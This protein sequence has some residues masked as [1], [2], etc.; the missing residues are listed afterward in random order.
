[1]AEESSFLDFVLNE[2][3][4]ASFL[5][6]LGRLPQPLEQFAFGFLH[7]LGGFGYR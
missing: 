2:S 5:R 6:P 1:M 7:V 4:L 3:R